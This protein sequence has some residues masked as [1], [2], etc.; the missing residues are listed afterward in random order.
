MRK[1]LVLFVASVAG[2]GGMSALLQLLPLFVTRSALNR[3]LRLEWGVRRAG[4][5][6]K[7]KWTEQFDNPH[8]RPKRSRHRHY[9]FPKPSSELLWSL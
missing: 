3:P 1:S 8:A 6:V 9:C 5:N 7:Q 4:T 2:E